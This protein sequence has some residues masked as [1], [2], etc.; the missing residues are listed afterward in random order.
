MTNELNPN[1]L[2]QKS[3]LEPLRY[4]KLIMKKILLLFKTKTIDFLAKTT[5]IT[6]L[7]INRNV[8]QSKVVRVNPDH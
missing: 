6:F 1:P 5:N 8:Y 2:V 7:I 4:Q 3:K